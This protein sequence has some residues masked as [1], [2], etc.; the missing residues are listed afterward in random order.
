MIT[1]KEKKSVLIK[2]ST[3]TREIAFLKCH[4]FSLTDEI[5]KDTSLVDTYVPMDT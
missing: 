1:K 5:M 2:S 4:T 3:Q